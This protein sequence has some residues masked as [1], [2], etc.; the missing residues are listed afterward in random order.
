M[1]RDKR[2]LELEGETLLHRTVAVLESIFQEVIIVGADDSL[3]EL[4]LTRV[5]LD[6]VPMRGSLGG[7]YTGLVYA[8]NPAIF[9]LACDMPFAQSTVIRKMVDF[10]ENADIVMAQLR[11]GIQPM[12]GVYSKSCLGHIRRMMDEGNLRIQ[13]LAC[14]PD[15]R[16][17]IVSETD[18][19]VSNEQVLSFMNVNTPADF[20]FARKLLNSR[21]R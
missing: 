18:L 15:L 3:K 6:L 16:V 21:P 10:G 17:R 2:F 4:N 13:E 5:E 7:L 8:K 19:Q 20:E 12:H 9:V 1:G 11:T 14:I